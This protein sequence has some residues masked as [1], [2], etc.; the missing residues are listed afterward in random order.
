MAGAG[1]LATHSL[2]EEK[3]VCLENVSALYPEY[4]QNEL[5]KNVGMNV[6]WV[7]FHIH[8]MWRSN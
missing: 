6:A 7:G 3:C 8:P 1:K 4:V 5:W 2:F